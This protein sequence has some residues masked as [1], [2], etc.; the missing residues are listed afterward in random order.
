[1]SGRFPSCLERAALLSSGAQSADVEVT[2][3]RM[4][5]RSILD[6]ER[7]ALLKQHI[8]EGEYAAVGSVIIEYLAEAAAVHAELLTQR[9]LFVAELSEITLDRVLRIRPGEIK[10]FSISSEKIPDAGAEGALVLRLKLCTEQSGPDGRR[11]RTLVHASAVVRLREE[12]S[13]PQAASAPDRTSCVEYRIPQEEFYDKGQLSRG[14][15]FQTVTSPLFMDPSGG[16]LFTHTSLKAEQR[17]LAPPLAHPVLGDCALQLL[18]FQA[19]VV[20]R[21]VRIPVGIGR[22]RLF[23]EPRPTS[24]YTVAISDPL[25][26]PET[27][28]SE[29]TVSTGDGWKLMEYSAAAVRRRPMPHDPAIVEGMLKKF[30]VEPLTGIL[31]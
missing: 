25:C 29:I 24:L 3:E 22:L 8:L 16:A 10:P 18:A 5:I 20:T 17:G 11:L 12:P 31:Q 6:P 9:P 27:C 21:T 26:T 13:L 28:V 1:M 14:P 15:L 4:E 23:P 2:G 7:I 19:K 30:R